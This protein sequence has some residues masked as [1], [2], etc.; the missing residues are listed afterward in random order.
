MSDPTTYPTHTACGSCGAST[1]LESHQLGSLSFAFFICP[2]CHL[3]FASVAGP[4]N[5][6][7][8][9]LD[10]LTNISFSSLHSLWLY[11]CKPRLE[12]LGGAQ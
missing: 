5:E 1:A 8:A 12:A 6:K 2:E 3:R 9:F 4:L 7:Q 10:W 11:S